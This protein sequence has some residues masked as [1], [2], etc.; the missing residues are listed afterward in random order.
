MED[1]KHAR[2]AEYAVLSMVMKRALRAGKITKNPCTIE[3][4][5]RDVSTRRPTLHTADVRML[6]ELSSDDQ[7]KG[8]L[9]GVARYRR[10]GRGDAGARLAGR[11]P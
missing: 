9:W 6:M 2:K 5:S 4:A 11:E 3:G 10:P 1:Q 7:M 8:S